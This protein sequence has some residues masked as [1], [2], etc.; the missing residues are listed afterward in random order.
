MPHIYKFSEQPQKGRKNGNH[1]GI[2]QRAVNISSEPEGYIICALSSCCRKWCTHYSMRFL[3][4]LTLDASVVQIQNRVDSATSSSRTHDICIH[5]PLKHIFNVVNLSHIESLHSDLHWQ[6]IR[7]WKSAMKYLFYYAYMQFSTHSP[8]LRLLSDG[9][10]INL[11]RISISHACYF[12][13]FQINAKTLHIVSNAS[14]ICTF[15]LTV[16]N[17]TAKM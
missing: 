12:T 6:C 13:P 11:H 1:T 17:I 5:T 8:W 2:F 3:P 15:W 7:E 16:L 9:M 4:P 10:S 14:F